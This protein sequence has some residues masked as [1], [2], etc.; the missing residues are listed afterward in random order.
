MALIQ[1]THNTSVSVQM[2]L[3]A[4]VSSTASDESSEAKAFLCPGPSVTDDSKESSV[5]EW[6]DGIHCAFCFG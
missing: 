5:Q 6:G 1:L 3:E 2:P 4:G